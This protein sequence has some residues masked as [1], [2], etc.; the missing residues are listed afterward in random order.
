MLHQSEIDSFNAMAGILDDVQTMFDALDEY[1]KTKQA[2][3]LY[4]AHAHEREIRKAMKKEKSKQIITN[5]IP[6]AR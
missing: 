3:W 5:P 4:A 2:V 6:H 1:R